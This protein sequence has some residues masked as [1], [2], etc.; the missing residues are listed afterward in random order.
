MRRIH[1]T[2][3]IITENCWQAAT[4]SKTPT[5]KRGQTCIRSNYYIQPCMQHNFDM[6]GIVEITTVPN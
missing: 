4:Y 6:F 5:T 3:I 2:S 1:V